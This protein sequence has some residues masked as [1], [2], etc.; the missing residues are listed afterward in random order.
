[1]ESVWA[2]N[3]D[4][5]QV[6]S[7]GKGFQVCVGCFNSIFCREAA[8]CLLISGI[9]GC[10][11]KA[12]IFHCGFLEMVHD[13][14]SSYGSIAY[15]WQIFLSVWLSVLYYFITNRAINTGF[16]TKLRRQIS[17]TNKQP[18]RGK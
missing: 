2:G 18:I 8:G 16:H 14:V 11:V 12:G 6:I 9:D 7:T 5:V 10:I 17:C 13:K 4:S 15:H 1:M 3:I